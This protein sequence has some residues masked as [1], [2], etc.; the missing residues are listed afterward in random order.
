LSRPRTRSFAK[1][2]VAGLIGGI[3]AIAAKNAAEKI[4]PPRTKRELKS[5][6]LLTHKG[7][8]KVLSIKQK[9]VAQQTMHWGLGAAAGA[10]YGTVAEVYPAATSKQGASFGM[11]L[12]ALNQDRTLP[13]LGR[14]AKAETQ[15][16]REHTSELVS[17]VVFGVVTETVRR[18]VRRMI[19]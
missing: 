4:Y 9:S 10:A 16:K 11:A 7:R 8:G 18:V 15:T 17:F 3:V 1:G 12:I 5:P 6:P 2:A 19:D 13:L 14:F